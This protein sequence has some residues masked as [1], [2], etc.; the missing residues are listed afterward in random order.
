MKFKLFYNAVIYSLD[1]DRIFDWMLVFGD[2][3]AALG[4]TGDLPDLPDSLMEK[5]DLDG[6]TVI[7]S[8]TDAHTHFASTALYE[9]QI[10]LH[11]AE[12]LDDAIKILTDKKI[13]F[14]RGNG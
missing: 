7:P 13:N 9:G 1:S 12:S 11:N 5:I 4:Q 8:F 10:S 3:I 2:R 14:C 6:R